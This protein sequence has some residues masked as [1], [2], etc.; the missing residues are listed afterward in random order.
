MSFYGIKDL[1]KQEITREQFKTKVETEI[2][3]SLFD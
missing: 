3:L 1:E 2:A